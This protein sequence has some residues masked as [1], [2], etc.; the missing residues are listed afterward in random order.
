VKTTT[1]NIIALMSI[2]ASIAAGA[3]QP[4]AASSLPV[5][6]V[7]LFTSGVAYTERGGSVEGDTEVGLTFR[8]AQINDI[9]K[10]MVLID[11]GGKVQPATYASRDPI[12][13]S[14]QA[15]AVDVSQNLTESD[16]LGRMRGGRI[17]IS[18]AGKP[19]VEG[20]I[21]GIEQRQL[22]TPGHDSN[23]VTA[24]YVNLLTDSGLI[25]VLLDAS[26]TLKV[27]DERLAREFKDALTLLASGMDDQKRQVK[28]HFSGAGRRDVHVGYVMESP[29]WKM[30][31]RLLIGGDGKPYLQ[32]WAH[33]ENTTDEDWKDVRLSLVSGRPVSFIQDLYQ[34]LYIPRPVV[35]PDVV[36]SPY[37]QT[38]DENLLAGA[39]A[40]TPAA[41]NADAFIG[42]GGAAGPSGEPGASIY[43]PTFA[44]AIGGNGPRGGSGGGIAG[45][46]P[47]ERRPASPTLSD[48]DIVKQSVDA[49]ASGQRSGELFQYS[50]AT[51]VNLRRQEA[52]MIPVIAQ[53]I[54]T[55]KVSL[56]NADTDGRYALNAV[57]VHNTTGLHLKGGSVTL[58]DAGVYAGD[59]RMEDVPPGDSRLISYAV[60]LS[61]ACERQGNPTVTV[62]TTVSVKR[63]VMTLNRRETTETVYVVKSKAD[64]ARNVLIEQPFNADY[65]LV[66]PAKAEEK[67]ASLYRFA[68]TVKPGASETLKVVQQRPLFQEITMLDGD[69]QLLVLTSNRKDISDKLKA[70][71]QEVIHRRTHVDELKAAAEQ[72]ANE[73]SSIGND[74]ERIRKNMEALDHS[75]ALYKRYVSELDTQETKIEA[76]R[77]EA[78]R[79]RTE[80]AA[81]QLELRAFVDGI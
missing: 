13:R 63:G 29:I 48:A 67:T 76:L 47:I 53:D 31:Y 64:K 26:K 49:A 24:T 30:S 60:D 5:K 68:L 78:I 43:N 6:Q 81:A 79:L 46:T 25:S 69:M 34:P 8:T 21:V 14:L 70:S 3:Q 35:G 57:R 59:A 66:S 7:T 19:T 77:Q 74:Q 61:L 2:A 17:A 71:L 4:E 41:V 22:P 11:Q 12:S 23:P 16:V 36:A 32:G 65:Q 62:D 72:R 45:H 54:E 52:A 38:H 1:T 73:V 40:K 55:E 18:E 56:F 39:Q 15:F 42:P 33:V 37:P 44:G 51:P 80:A 10:S 28:L 75:S 58:F 20:Q 9:L 27:L 50:I